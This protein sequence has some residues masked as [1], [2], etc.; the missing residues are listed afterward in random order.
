MTT[1]NPLNYNGSKYF[2]PS[3][4]PRRRHRTAVDYKGRQL[5][6]E[7]EADGYY[8]PATDVD[9]ACYPTC[10]IKTVE[11]ATHGRAANGEWVSVLVDVTELMEGEVDE[12]AERVEREWRGEV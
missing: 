10:N 11:L 3:G 9:D 4:H 5:W 1:S 12:I 8:A 6:V 7:Y 2:T